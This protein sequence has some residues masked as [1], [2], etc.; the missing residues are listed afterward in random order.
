MTPL[1]APDLSGQTRGGNRPVGRRSKRARKSTAR[2]RWVCAKCERDHGGTRPAACGCGSTKFS[3]ERVRIELRV[4]P[5][6]RDR[7]IFCAS[8]EGY[9][10]VSDWI[11]D[12]CNGRVRARVL[13]SS[14]MQTHNTPPEI[15]S[16]IKPFGKI[17]LDPCSNAGS[18]V[19]AR[20]SWT[21][22][23]DGLPRSW[24]IP[25]TGIVYVNPPYGE[26]LPTWIRK[27]IEE[28]KRG[29]E[30]IALVPARTDTQWFD[31]ASTSADV[32][33]WKGRITYRGSTN[34]APFPICLLYFGPRRALFRKALERKCVRILDAAEPVWRRAKVSTPPAAR[35]KRAA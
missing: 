34:P 8:R 18:I 21:E 30:I 6:E 5:G 15:L 28:A 27:M 31:L 25:G 2:K 9:F 29:A 22:Q 4:E 13:T 7:W 24:L 32:A 19:R 33:L 14:D 11:R 3:D 12:T 1:P 20:V 26:A 17:L 23:D 16:A 35:T 10:S